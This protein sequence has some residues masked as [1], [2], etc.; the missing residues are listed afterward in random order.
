[1]KFFFI[2][3]EN[4]LARNR[5]E[6]GNETHEKTATGRNF[7]AASNLTEKHDFFIDKP[8]ET[9]YNISQRFSVSV[10]FC[11]QVLEDEIGFKTVLFQ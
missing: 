1:M 6:R 3:R 11:V 10:C 5:Q 4:G 2:K 7:R 8:G 9:S